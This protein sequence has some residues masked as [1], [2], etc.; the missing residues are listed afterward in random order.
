MNISVANMR[1]GVRRRRLLLISE[2]RL[3]QGYVDAAHY[4]AFTDNRIP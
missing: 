3:P 2:K 1:G 4:L